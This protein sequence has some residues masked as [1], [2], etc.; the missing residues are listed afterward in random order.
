MNPWLISNLE[1]G[2]SPKAQQM[3]H[4]YFEHC[5]NL[6][7]GKI[8]LSGGQTTPIT[9]TEKENYC[10]TECFPTVEGN[11]VPSPESI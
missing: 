4:D 3:T 2:I 10:G 11:R 8:L 7:M 6:A 1:M 9:S 5:L